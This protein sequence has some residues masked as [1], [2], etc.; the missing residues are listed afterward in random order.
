MS[1]RLNTDGILS[2][3]ET[4]V[5]SGYVS[6]MIA[7]EI[8]D[9]C[10]ISPHTVVRHT[11]NIYGKAGIGHST[12]A[13]VAWFLEKNLNLDLSEFRRRVGAVVLLGIITIQVCATDFDSDFVRQGAS[14]RT[15]TARRAG[16][17]RRKDNDYTTI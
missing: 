9:A 12:N 14:R 16:R 15:E 10:G 5:A 3:A 13:L 11:Q 1:E 17:G 2:P 4:R 6:G 8:A 7:K